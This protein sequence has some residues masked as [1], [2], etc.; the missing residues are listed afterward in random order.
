MGG[1]ALWRGG[2]DPGNTIYVTFV[3]YS[4]NIL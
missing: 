1:K 3:S 4:S 2:G